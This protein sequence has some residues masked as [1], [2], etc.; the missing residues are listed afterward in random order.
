MFESDG[1]GTDDREASPDCFSTTFTGLASFAFGAF[2]LS[3]SGGNRD[4][5]NLCT[6]AEAHADRGGHHAFD[7]VG[8]FGGAV[9]GATA[10]GESEFVELGGAFFDGAR[11][12]GL[13]VFVFDLDGGWGGVVAGATVEG[14]EQSNEISIANSGFIDFF[15]F[16]TSGAE[17]VFDDGSFEDVAQFVG[18]RLFE[19]RGD[20]GHGLRVWVW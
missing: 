4:R 14:G 8:D 9:F 2:V 3:P 17:E 5:V 10:V 18:A 11:N 12:V 20:G 19:D 1:G 15:I 16:A 13:L 7:G 6:D